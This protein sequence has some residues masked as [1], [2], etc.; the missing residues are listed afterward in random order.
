MGK[1]GRKRKASVKSAPAPEGEIDGDEVKSKQSIEE[2]ISG[3]QSEKT[4]LIIEK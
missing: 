2:Q 1:S 4:A 3:L